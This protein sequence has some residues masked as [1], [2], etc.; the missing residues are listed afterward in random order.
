[1]KD[2]NLSERDLLN[3]LYALAEHNTDTA[4]IKGTIIMSQEEVDNLIKEL[5][6]VDETAG[7]IIEKYFDGS[8]LGYGDEIYN[9]IGVV[10]DKKFLS[11]YNFMMDHKQYLNIYRTL[12]EYIHGIYDEFQLTLETDKYDLSDLMS[13]D[14]TFDNINQLEL[15]SDEDM[16]EAKEM[17]KYCKGGN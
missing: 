16:K 15:F 8:Y 10:V 7:E 11:D 2:N 6:A 3:A 9:K 14:S 17:K 13:V 12:A 1:M 4:N 5:K